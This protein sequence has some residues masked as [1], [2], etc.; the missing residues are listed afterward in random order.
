MSRPARHEPRLRPRG[1]LGLIAILA[2]AVLVSIGGAAGLGGG[3]DSAAAGCGRLNADPHVISRYP[4][5]FAAQFEKKLRVSVQR[6]RAKVRDWRVQLYTFGGYLLGES[7]IDK[8]MAGT[9][10]ASMKLRQAL[11]PGKYTLVTK[12][13][14]RGCGEVELDQVVSFRDCLGKLPIKFVEKPGGTAADYGRYLSI[15]IAPKPLWAPLGDI[16]GSV[17]NFDGDVY[18]RAELPR[19]E[20]K[21]IG[22]QTLDFKLKSGGLQ[23]GGYSVYITGKARQPRSCGDLSKST[24]LEFK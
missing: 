16:R 19:G 22:T 12:G 1:V 10:T 18:G 20:G 11:Q 13:T 5:P 7:K 9:D 17:S 21:L 23:P 24:V 3:P 2:V 8:R 15:K 4:K 6:G 14:V